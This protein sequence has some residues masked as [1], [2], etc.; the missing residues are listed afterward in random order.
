MAAV[1]LA[2]QAASSIFI[3]IFSNPEKTNGAGQVAANHAG[4]GCNAIGSAAK[5]WRRHTQA[6]AVVDPE[7]EDA[8]WT[9]VMAGSCCC[10]SVLRG[11]RLVSPVR[12]FFNRF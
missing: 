7:D 1:F 3:I 4:S 6:A 5:R 10:G 12:I 11:S 8:R 9:S 2:S